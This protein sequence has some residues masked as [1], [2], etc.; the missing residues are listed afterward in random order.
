[1]M[2]AGKVPFGSTKIIKSR[3]VAYLC[4]NAEFEASFAEGNHSL[5][6]ILIAHGYGYG[7]E[8]HF[9]TS[10]ILASHGYLCVLIS[11]MDGSAPY[12]TGV[13]GEDIIF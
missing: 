9:A 10:M 2:A 1:M 6:P 11:F 4:L 13:Q 8:D 5:I 12:T 7:P 3:K